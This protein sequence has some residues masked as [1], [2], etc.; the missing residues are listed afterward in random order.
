MAVNCPICG[1]LSQRLLELPKFPITEKY[2]PWTPDFV[3][4]RFLVDQAFRFCSACSHGFL[5]TVVPNLYG[6]DYRTTTGRSEGATLAVKNFHAFVMEHC[7]GPL[8][9]V[10]DIGAN[11][12]TL[13]NL[14]TDGQQKVA[15]DKCIT[16]VGIEDVDLSQYKNHPKLIL[17]SH[18]IEHL[19]DPHVM[20][21]KCADVMRP[22]DVLALQFPSLDLLVE[23]AR[24]DQIH[25]Q[26]LHY[27]SHWSIAKL[28][29]Q[30]GLS[31]GVS[32]FDHSHW[33]ALQVIAR[34]DSVASSGKQISPTRFLSAVEDF[35]AEMTSFAVPE[36]AIA[37]GAA[38][39][40]PVLAYWLEDLSQVV[41]IADD[42]RAKDG[43]R[44][45]TFNKPIRWD[46]NLKGEDVVITAI[47]SKMA[48]RA[49][50]KKAIDAGARRVIFPLHTL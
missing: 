24:I 34:K 30:H 25:H 47:G 5:E 37:L 31:I 49:L 19:V 26:H 9:L 40:L 12:Y 41:M 32:C 45:V 42:D 6:A 38:L 22:D 44:Y 27:F 43:L 28:L 8:R 46:Y 16:G 35:K 48:A 21:R 14:F 15:I 29:K 17:S 20:V 1:G 11:D 7:G 39:M 13:L 10:I 36:G 2:E 4:G 50:T 18:T 33:G 3:P 23:D